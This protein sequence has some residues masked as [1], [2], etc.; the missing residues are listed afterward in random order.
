MSDNDNE[1]EEQLAEA[2]AQIESLQGAAADAEA[3]AATAREELSAARNE[4]DGLR[5]QLAESEEARGLAASTIAE[6]EARAESVRGE[7]RGAVA[8]YRA[9]RLSAAPDIPHDLVPEHETV[10]DVDREFESAQRVVGQLREKIE[11]EAVEQARAARVPAGAPA[12]RGTDVSS[13][14]AGEKIKLGLQ[15]LD[16][17]GR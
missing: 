16:R 7:L 1:L 15:R 12:R 2:R 3:R 6:L 14:S 10:E 13:L 11:R 8:K 17:T 5:S 4:Q 9:A